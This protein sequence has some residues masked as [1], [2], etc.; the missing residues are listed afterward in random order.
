MQASIDKVN[1]LKKEG[2]IEVYTK[3]QLNSVSGNEKVESNKYKA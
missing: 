3:Y 2:K 1:Q